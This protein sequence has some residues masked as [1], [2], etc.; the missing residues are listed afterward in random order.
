[1]QTFGRW[2]RS[3][4][5][6]TRPLTAS[7]RDARNQRDPRARTARRSRLLWRQRGIY[8]SQVAGRWRATERWLGRT[9]H[10]PPVARAR[11]RDTDSQAHARIANVVVLTLS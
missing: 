8:L 6:S 1:M 3:H 2:S 5:P 9:D 4:S 11:G 7:C 10:Q